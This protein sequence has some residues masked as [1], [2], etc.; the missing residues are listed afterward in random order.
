MSGE[1][2][3]PACQIGVTGKMIRK[4]LVA[5]AAPAGFRQSLLHDLVQGQG[6]PLRSRPPAPHATVE[7]RVQRLD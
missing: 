6:V 5:R 4:A 7:G 1:P 3:Q 2:E